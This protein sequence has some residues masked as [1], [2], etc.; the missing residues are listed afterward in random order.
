MFEHSNNH[1][2][3]LVHQPTHFGQL[4]FGNPGKFDPLIQL[5]LDQVTNCH[6]V[7]TDPFKIV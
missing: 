1:L 6:T 7:V 4:P 5:A 2:I 3:E